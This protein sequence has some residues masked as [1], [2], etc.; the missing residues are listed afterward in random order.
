MILNLKDIIK[1]KKS[2]IKKYHIF[3]LTLTHKTKFIYRSHLR[4][5]HVPHKAGLNPNPALKLNL[6][7]YSNYCCSYNMQL[8]CRKWYDNHLNTRHGI[9]V[10]NGTI[11]PDWSNSNNYCPSC[12]TSFSNIDVYQGL[13]RH[14]H[15]MNLQD[16]TEETEKLGTTK[17][18]LNN[19]NFFTVLFVINQIQT[20]LVIATITVLYMIWYCFCY[21]WDPTQTQIF[22]LIHSIQV[23]AAKR[24]I[25]PLKNDM[26]ILCTYEEFRA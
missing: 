20:S 19:P 6:E 21:T 3:I 16:T 11:L 9:K 26:F 17:P 22:C 13:C 2:T 14:I 4:N 10:R 24:A 8:L 15:K 18:D 23:A 25:N 5:R 1:Y 12:E 7:D